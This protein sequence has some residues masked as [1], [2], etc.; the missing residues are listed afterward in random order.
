VFKL[1]FRVREHEDGLSV[2][3]WIGRALAKRALNS[4]P[5]AGESEPAEWAAENRYAIPRRWERETA[6]WQAKRL[7]S[8]HRAND[9]KWEHRNCTELALDT[10]S[11]K[12]KWAEKKWDNA[13]STYFCALGEDVTIWY[14][15]W[16]GVPGEWGPS[17]GRYTVRWNGGYVEACSDADAPSPDSPSNT[18]DG[19]ERN[20]N[21]EFL[22][23]LVQERFAAGE[24]D[25]V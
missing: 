11:G 10:Q 18:P 9:W 6:E 23:H 4:A 12:L 22:F 20:P 7:A 25:V 24:G 14:R 5:E 8:W 13:E 21:V 3:G 19:W 15:E 16:G 17:P 1:G 2:H